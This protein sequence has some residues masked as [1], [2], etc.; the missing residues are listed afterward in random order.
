M[1]IF[2]T[3]DDVRQA[4]IGWRASGLRTALVPTMGNLHDGHLA[5]VEAACKAHDKVIVSLYVNPT[6]F[7]AHEDLDS[8]PRTLAQDKEA[9]AAYGAK[10]SLFAPES[11]YQEGHQTMIVPQGAALPLEGAHRPQFFTGVA[12][13]VYLLFQAVPA[14]SAYFGEKDF[15]QLAV[16]RQMVADFALPITICSV[17]TIRAADGVALSSRNG[18]LSEQDRQIAPALYQQM[19]DCAQAIARGIS[20]EQ[21]CYEACEHLQR[22][23]FGKI[24]YFAFHN[25]KTLMPAD[26]ITG[27]TRLMAALWLGNTR[28]IDNDSVQ[29]LCI[30]Q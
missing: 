17:P 19:Q 30:A 18:Y 3:S 12:T 24:D 29:N 11:L 5:L 20:Y 13:V 26:D 14:H 10:V 22:A 15:Q 16:I 23:G 1:K 7:A 27:E 8:Y 2:E 25:P 28:L 21:A 4:V 6:Q 9:L